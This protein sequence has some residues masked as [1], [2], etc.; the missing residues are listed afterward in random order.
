M[1]NDT[2][3][4]TIGIG[5]VY[6]KN[7][8]G[9]TKVLTEVRYVPDM[10]KNFIS[11]GVLESKRLMVTMRDEVLKIVSGALV[12]LKGTR[13]NNLYYYDSNTIIGTVAVATLD[14]ERSHATKL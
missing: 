12:M 9:S 7:H 6:L 14:D 11:L 2:F 13:K 1:G 3:C 5:S 4:E 10:K 8:D